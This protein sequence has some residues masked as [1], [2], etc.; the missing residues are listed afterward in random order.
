[1]SASP[2]VPLTYVVSPGWKD[3][4][5]VSVALPAATPSDGMNAASGD[6]RNGMYGF[7]GADTS[8]PRMKQEGFK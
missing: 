3:P 6:T 5:P 8:K 1:M 4:S 2:V 7:G